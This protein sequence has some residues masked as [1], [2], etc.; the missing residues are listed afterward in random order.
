M[1]RIEI[2]NANKHLCFCL[3]CVFHIQ[4]H[5][6]VVSFYHFDPWSLHPRNVLQMK[7]KTNAYVIQATSQDM[8]W[9]LLVRFAFR[10]RSNLLWPYLQFSVLVKSQQKSALFIL[11]YFTFTLSICFAF[12]SGVFRVDFL[13]YWWSLLANSLSLDS[14]F[15]CMITVR[16]FLIFMV[17]IDLMWFFVRL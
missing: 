14:V 17:M 11:F 4:N 12:S 16:Q 9:T 15:V 6:I 2:D 8:V 3:R 5:G 1:H 7:Y 10:N 13:V